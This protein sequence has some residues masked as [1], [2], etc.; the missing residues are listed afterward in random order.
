MDQGVLSRMVE[1]GC[2]PVV[3]RRMDRLSAG[4]KICLERLS[5]PKAISRLSV[6]GNTIA[7][8][9]ERMDLLAVGATTQMDKPR[10]Q[11]EPL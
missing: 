3:S 6:Q 10:L 1:A 9:L 7:A 4:D 8:A 5:L 2:I 11:E